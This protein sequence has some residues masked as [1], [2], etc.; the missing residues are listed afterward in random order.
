MKRRNF[1]NL[2]CGSAALSILPFNKL[3]AFDHWS[4]DDEVLSKHKIDR[5]LLK[6]V[7]LKYPR[8]VGKNAAKDI[9]GWGPTVNVAQLFTDQGAS[10]WGLFAAGASAQTA[11]EF[12]KGKPL[13]A[14]F[15]TQKGV[16][17]PEVLAF[18]F[19]L[20]D[21]AGMILKKPVYE[22]LGA[23]KPITTK[24]YSGMIYFDDLEP[25]EA[26]G[27]IDAILKEC[28]WDRNYGYRQ[29][30]VKIGRGGKW[31]DPAEGVKRDI[32]VTKQIAKA[33]PDCEILVDGNDKMTT[34]MLIQYLEGIAGITLFWIEEPF[35]ESEKD[36][37]VIRNWLDKQGNK[38]TFL[39]DGE[40]N[41]DL[42]LALKLAEKKL[43]DVYL[44]DI[45]NIGFTKWR[46]LNPMLKSKGILSSPHNWGM[47]L[48]TYYTGH[49]I[50]AQGNCPTIEGV[51]CL[52]DDVD[53]GDNKL[54]NGL[55]IPSAAPGFG[56]SLHV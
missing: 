53:Y 32:E 33:F 15:S 26:P 6:K 34:D 47:S 36:Y 21:L 43:L 54:K 35:R 1:I 27:G 24:C 22:L 30:K 13:S 50:G 46:T 11:M 37:A 14:F 23:K 17:T 3:N 49:L 28:E 7:R 18:D 20:H 8:L 40:A 56:M 5:V 38:K 31:M 52:T 10:G 51:T 12:V 42:E 2:A 55:L 4:A 29:L 9:H 44:D 25:K 48:K 19:A 41:A 16:L 45:E 39:A